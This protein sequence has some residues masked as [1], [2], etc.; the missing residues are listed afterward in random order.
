MDANFNKNIKRK[1]EILPTVI[2][3]IVSLTMAVASIF[4]AKL[5]PEN[6]I[7]NIFLASLVITIIFSVIVMKLMQKNFVQRL[8]NLTYGLFGFFSYLKGDSDKFA[9]I[10][11]VAGDISAEI[12]KN[13]KQIEI[14]L[15]KDKAFMDELVKVLEFVK[16]GDYDKRV[17]QT[18][19]SSN[20]KEIYELINHT[21][22]KIEKDVGKDLKLI[23]DRLN[24]YSHEDYT[25]SISNPIG[26]LEKSINQLRDVIVHMLKESRDF[27][28][29]FE[30]RASIV[31]Q[32]INKVYKNIDVDITRELSKIIYAIDEVSK[33]IKSNVEGA[34]FMQSYSDEVANAAKEGEE[35]AKKTSDAMRDIS[36]EVDRI[37]DA[38]SV[39]DKIT[40]QTNILSLNAAVEA[41]SAGEAGKGFAVVASE[42]RNLAS[43]TSIA[44]KEIQEVVD[45]AKK[46]SEYANGISSKMILGYR[47]LVS[48]V[49]GSIDYIHK[50]TKNSNIQ[51]KHIDEIDEMVKNMQDMMIDSLQ[52]L[53]EANKQSSDNRESSKKLLEF[54]HSKKFETA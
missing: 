45:V 13:F 34:S 38:I 23:V 18:P 4:I 35:L 2:V 48:K 47:D 44:A 16:N 46:K 41:S 24:E 25:K 8:D 14:N 15:V 22:D 29:E 42:V 49:Q 5:S 39:I 6:L 11:D 21:L 52:L 51:D 1:L 30:K 36:T 37:N 26:T 12:N 7:Q 20:L 43:Q 50:I 40:V 9:Y 3:T 10:D 54:T 17:T 33:H 53:K 27:G 19:A 31:N 28:E 32:K